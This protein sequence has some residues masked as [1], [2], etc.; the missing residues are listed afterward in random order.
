MAKFPAK[1]PSFKAVQPIVL[2]I[3]GLMS[4]G[5]QVVF[6]DADRPYLLAVIAG[7][8]GLPFVLLADKAR[9]EGEK[10]SNGET[11]NTDH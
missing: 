5:W 2:F 9:N 1:K 3:F 6:E 4:F 11:A 7:M 10:E 8:L